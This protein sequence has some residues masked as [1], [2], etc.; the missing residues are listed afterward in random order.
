MARRLARL[1]LVAVFPWAGLLATV[2][3]AAGQANG[4]GRAVQAGPVAGVNLFTLSGSDASGTKTLTTFY[5]GGALTLP[6]G[7]NG[8][9]ELQLL[10]AGKGASL[11]T[12]DPRVGTVTGEI[13]L[14]YLELPVLVGFDLAPVRD[15][16]SGTPLGAGGG[17]RPRLYAGPTIGIDLRCDVAASN[18]G[19]PYSIPCPDSMNVVDLGATF[20][21]G[22][23]FPVGRATLSF[24][25][26]LTIGLTP[27]FVGSNAKNEGLSIGAR[28]V[29][30]LPGKKG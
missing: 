5:V 15:R 11:S 25:A 27:V 12:F 4:T 19:T 1:L 14:T 7:E 20:G 8:F 21:G 18:Y 13:K 17:T 3:S 30:P 26:R 28:F 24:D 16:R 9:V 23:S 6:I 29:F 22:I 10:Y 2:T